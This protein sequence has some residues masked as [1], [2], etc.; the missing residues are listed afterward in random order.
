MSS[1]P[2][3]GKKFDADVIVLGAGMAGLAAA[4]VLA[5]AGKYVLVLEAR[6]RV[7]GRV[8]TERT[9]SGVLV[10]HGAEFIHGRVDELWS[11]IEEAGVEAVERDGELLR[12][13]DRGAGLVPDDDERDESFFAPLET[14]ADLRPDED[15]SFA[16]WIAG[17]D[18][19][20]WQ[21]EALTGYV[22]GFNAAD[23]ER[24]SARSIGVQQ[25]AESASEGD[26]SW[27]LPGGYAQLAEFLG[28]K[29]RAA[30]AEIRLN[31]TVDALHWRR[32][33]AVVTTRTAKLRAPRCIVALPLGVLQAANAG[34]RGSVRLEP[35]PRALF[36]AR[37]LAMGQVVR[38]T[39]V[40]R[41]RWWEIAGQGRPSAPESLRTL[42]FLFTPERTPPVWW[43][44]RPEPE[45]MP[46]LVGWSGGPRSESLR[47]M[48]AEQLGA[49]ACGELAEVFGLPAELVRSTLV[50]THTYDWSS[51]PLALGAY[52][53]VPARALD[54]PAA[55]AEPVA[56]TL[57]FAGEHTDTTGH[58]GTVHAALRSGLR[59]A[60]QVLGT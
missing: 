3:S 27:H 7:G 31:D 49:H 9:A 54:A 19:P 40:F 29:A 30:G 28:E 55:M 26:R 5:E 48:S 60:R 52:S 21:R 34:T 23:A 32:G 10:E 38:F 2:G 51:D 36:E 6:D 16:E 14:L 1:P 43:T 53:Y 59:A 50:S 13:E 47:S 37:T 12:E 15:L 20:A 41:E 17:S 57:Y 33:D 42:S 56:D 18:V 46:T 25:R 8:Y 58:W 22:E 39:L 24:I 11:L 35:E 4:R 44:R 45:A